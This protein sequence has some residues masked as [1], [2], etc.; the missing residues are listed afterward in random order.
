MSLICPAALRRIAV[1]NKDSI[2]EALRSVKD[3]IGDG[4]IVAEKRVEKIT[5]EG[6]SVM[7]T[8]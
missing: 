3:I 5:V 7:I 6:G 8:L 4:D 2:E 1:L